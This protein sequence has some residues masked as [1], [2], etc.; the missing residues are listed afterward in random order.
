MHTSHAAI[1]T[2]PIDILLECPEEAVTIH[3]YNEK[4]QQSLEQVHYFA[5][6]NL[7]L[8]SDKMNDYY[9]IRANSKV[10][11]TGDTVWLHNP[12][13]KPGLSFTQIDASL[14]GAIHGYKN[15]QWRGILP[16]V[17]PSK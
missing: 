16:S 2:R 14:G 4:V 5:I 13:W 10:L 17:D 6:E 7:Q 15:N 1:T 8:A 3:S 9:D 11:Q 12:K